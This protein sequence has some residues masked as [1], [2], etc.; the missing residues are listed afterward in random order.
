MEKAVLVTGGGRGIGRAICRALARDGWMVMLNYQHNE[1]AAIQ[2]R[3]AIK[4]E[5]GIAESFRADVAD[6]DSVKNMLAEIK[7]R[8]YWVNALVNNAGI[9]RDNPVPMMTLDEWQS[10][11]STN[12]NGA[13]FCIKEVIPKMMV[14]RSGC[15]V[16][17][18][19][20]SGIRGQVGQAN[21]GAAKA[22]MLAVTRSLAREVGRYNIRV[23]AVAPGFIETEMLDKMRDNPKAKALLEEAKESHIPLQRFGHAEEVAAVVSFLLSEAAS[24]VTGQTLVVDGGLSA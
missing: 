24:Y 18:A 23:N 2:V 19:S 15:I 13:F 21:Y 6:R 3:D 12:L 16:N 4:A 22:G 5:G 8:G 7:E 1:A 14:R 9:T 10:V 17:I 20:V 11:L